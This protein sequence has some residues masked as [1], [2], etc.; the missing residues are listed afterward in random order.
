MTRLIVKALLVAA[1]LSAVGYGLIFS[2]LAV[3]DDW[4]Q[5]CRA[6]DVLNATGIVVFLPSQP[7]FHEAIG[8]ARFLVNTLLWGVAC[9]GA[10]MLFKVKRPVP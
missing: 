10:F 7:F 2:P 9:V 8:F 6:G 1:L 5:G 3:C 4:K